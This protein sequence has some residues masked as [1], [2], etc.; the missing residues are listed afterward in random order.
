MTDKIFLDSKKCKHED[1]RL[2]GVGKIDPSF[3]WCANCDSEWHGGNWGFQKVVKLIERN[4]IKKLFTQEEIEENWN[5]S[6]EELDLNPKYN[7]DSLPT[8]F[9]RIKKFHEIVFQKLL[10]KLKL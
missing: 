10:R 5:E 3:F 8:E 1:I 6:I 9:D 4:A 7:G 2:Q